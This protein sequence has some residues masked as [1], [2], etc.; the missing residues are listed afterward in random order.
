ML[1]TRTAI[2]DGA[3]QCIARDGVRKTTMGDVSTEARI[4][5]ATLYNHFRTKDDLIAALVL[6]RTEQLATECAEL[7][8]AGLAP[9]L[10]HAGRWLAGSAA[11]R[12]VATT[13]P[14]VAALLATP[15]T[16][17]SWQAARR[18]V[19]TVLREAGAP[20]DEAAVDVVL[21]WLCGQVLWAAN[22]AELALGAQ[23]LADGL[24]RVP[25]ALSTVEPA[26]ADAR[27]APPGLGWPA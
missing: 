24:G 18:G 3:A 25:D 17:R 14:A 16:G 11:L 27:P 20:S 12:R 10:E 2:L 19:T 9:A 1:R 4:A 23:V 7:A 5:K 26:Y 6:A 8:V 22:D 15:G 21:R 13:E